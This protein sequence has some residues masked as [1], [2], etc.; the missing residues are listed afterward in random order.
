[1]LR[2]VCMLMFSPAQRALSFA[3]AARNLY[4]DIALA[5]ALVSA[6]RDAHFHSPSFTSFRTFRLIRS[7]FRA[8]MWLM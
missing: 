3:S 1:M 7:R 8:L 2:S 4:P 6:G 5:S